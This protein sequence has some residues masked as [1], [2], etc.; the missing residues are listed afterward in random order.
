[1]ILFHQGSLIVKKLAQERIAEL[2]KLVLEGYARHQKLR[3]E[4]DLITAGKMD[5]KIDEL[6]DELNKQAEEKLRQES[7]HQKWLKDREVGS[8]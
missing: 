2:E 3:K 8:I 4:L 5:D 1:M 6:I 7:V